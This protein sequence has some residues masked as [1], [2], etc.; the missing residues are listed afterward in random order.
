MKGRQTGSFGGL[1]ILVFIAGRTLA[2]VNESSIEGPP[3]RYVTPACF[4]EARGM[5]N[6]RNVLKC[7]S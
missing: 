7:Y 5:Q 2:S 4:S 6:N 1:D 3:F